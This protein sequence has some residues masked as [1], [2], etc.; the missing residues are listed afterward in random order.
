VKFL[1]LLPWIWMVTLT[2]PLATLPSRAASIDLSILN[3][4]RLGSPGDV[5]TFTG[6]ITNDTE[7]PLNSTDLFLN[8]SAFDPVTVT[9]DQ[10]LGVTNFVI[11]D[12]STSPV[13]NLFTFTLSNTAG[14]GTYPAQVVLQ[15]IVGDTSGPQTVSVTV[16]AV[17][18][19]GSFA[20]VAITGLAALLVW[21]RRRSRPLLPVILISGVASQLGTAQVTSVRFVTGPSGLGVIGSTLMIAQPIRN[22]GTVNAVNVQVT[23]ATLRTATL[24]APAVFPV[25]LG[26]IPPANSAVFEASFNASAL[27]S[28]TP[29]L[30]TVRGTYQVGGIAA[31]FAVNRFITVPPA[32]PGSGNV[33]TTSV[34]PISVSGAPFPHQPPQFDDEVNAPRPPVPTGP[35]VAGLQGPE[36]GAVPLQQGPSIGGRVRAAAQVVFNQNSGV[37]INSAGTNCNPGVQPASCAEPSGASGG[38]V[39]F[40]SANWTAAYSTNGGSTFTVIDP[41][42]IFPADAIGFCCDQVVQYVPSIDRFIWLLQGSGGMRIASASPAQ[43]IN[44]GGTAWT[45]WNLGVGIFGQPA[46]TGFDYPDVSVGTNS[47]YLSW[48]VG[49]PACPAG[50]NSGF[51]VVR[52]PLSQ[53]QASATIFFDTRRLPTVPWHG[54]AISVRTP[55]TKSSGRVTTATAHY[56]CS[57]LPKDRT[58]TSGGRSGFLVGPTT[59]CPPP[60]LTIRTGSS[61]G[62]RATA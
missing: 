42:T 29:Y 61:S 46:G 39:V 59:P 5:V 10:L 34:N 62:F 28:N 54:V 6:T 44:S 45:Y 17:P 35:F 50:C 38:G 14:P 31:G 57:R 33:H 56:A 52:I 23:D 47:L 24:T 18:E 40:V 1:R 41:T 19:P 15:T 51:E 11:P 13:V 49:F 60:L 8:F 53:I 32:S 7:D 25:T 48:D 12:G 27:V 2:L 55:E 37:G 9:L 30:L 20:L 43:I 4:N 3:P 36:S 22:D 26:T 16:G 21:M 58:R